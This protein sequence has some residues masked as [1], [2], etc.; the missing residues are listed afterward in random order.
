MVLR[1]ILAAEIDRDA[2]ENRLIQLR[3][4]ELKTDAMTLA[5]VYRQEGR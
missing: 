1:Y 2:F 4:P 3:D 5:Q